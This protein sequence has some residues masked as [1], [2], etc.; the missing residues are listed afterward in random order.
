MKKAGFDRLFSCPQEDT[1]A[2]RPIMT[3]VI[4]ASANT[5]VSPVISSPRGVAEMA[6]VTKL[7]RSCTWLTRAMPPWLPEAG[8]GEFLS[9]RGLRDDQIALIQ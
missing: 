1:L 2:Q 9:P 6:S 4:T 8:H 5:S 7:C 3:T